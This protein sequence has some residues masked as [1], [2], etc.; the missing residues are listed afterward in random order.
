VRVA[1][2]ED[3]DFDFA[4]SAFHYV[5]VLEIPTPSW[6]VY[7]RK[8]YGI[9]NPKEAVLRQQERALHFADLVHAGR[10]TLGLS[11]GLCPPQHLAV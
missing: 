6:L 10:L 8:V 4:Q 7:D 3:P 5:R 11:G 9:E 1:Y 2:W